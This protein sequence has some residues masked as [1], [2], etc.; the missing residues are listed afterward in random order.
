M[1][2]E[3]LINLIIL[4][5]FLY[6]TLKVTNISWYKKYKLERW[7]VLKKPEV[8][9]VVWIFFYIII[10]Y[11]WLSSSNHSVYY[12]LSIL[13]YLFLCLLLCFLIV[14]QHNNELSIFFGIISS[15]ILLFICSI[16]YHYISKTNGI[17][18]I[19]P[20]IWTIYLII[21]SLHLKKTISEHIN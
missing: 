11:V 17:L 8:S 20:T 13:F 1:N 5:L 4:L 9:T 21:E 7:S 10:I 15:I 12:T 3:I 6:I 2:K 18:L 16:V 14:I 19:L